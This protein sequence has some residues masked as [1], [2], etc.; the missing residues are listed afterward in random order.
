MYCW[1]VSKSSSQIAFS[2]LFRQNS[3][4]SSFSS[5]F[6]FPSSILI[7]LVI[8][9]HSAF[10]KQNHINYAACFDFLNFNLALW[11]DSTLLEITVS[12]TYSSLPSSSSVCF[13]TN[14][15]KSWIDRNANNWSWYCFI[16][17]SNKDCFSNFTP[18]KDIINIFWIR[19]QVR[20]VSFS[21][22][23]RWGVA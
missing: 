22:S 8:S 20:N 5:S 12:I 9:F 19:Y 15:S 17:D 3:S 16:F 7:A 21:C 23:M 2:L 11:A 13:N 6:L 4:S 10:D 14:W 1:I 18:D